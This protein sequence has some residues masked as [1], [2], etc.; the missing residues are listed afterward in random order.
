MLPPSPRKLC[1]ILEF[2]VNIL[3]SLQGGRSELAGAQR[4]ATEQQGQRQL[5]P[6]LH[7]IL[8]S[9]SLYWL[10]CRV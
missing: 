3:G 7:H 4:R 8:L 6:E 2:C 1:S 9:R 10:E 5:L